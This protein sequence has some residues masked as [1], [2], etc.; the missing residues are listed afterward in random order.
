M[1]GWTGTRKTSMVFTPPSA[2]YIRPFPR[3]RG[4]KPLQH[5][6]Y[7]NQKNATGE[8][9]SH[10][11]VANMIKSNYLTS[12]LRLVPSLMRMMLMPR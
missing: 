1:K 4:R 2:H 5:A 10:S 9:V 3:Y 11:P 6:E 12:I 7:L 8:C